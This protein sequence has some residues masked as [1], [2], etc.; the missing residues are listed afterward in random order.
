MNTGEP[1]VAPDSARVLRFLATLAYVWACIGPLALP[2]RIEWAASVYKFREAAPDLYA[3]Y[4][5]LLAMMVISAALGVIALRGLRTTR[6]CR[7]SQRRA[8]AAIVINIASAA[9]L[10]IG[11]LEFEVPMRG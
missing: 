3:A 6:D 11:W 8:L 1:D 7:R 9:S 10:L 5:A 4:W 2:V